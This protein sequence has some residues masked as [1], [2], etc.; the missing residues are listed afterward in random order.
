M[1]NLENPCN[2]YQNV[3]IY[4]ITDVGYTECYIGSTLQQLCNR[5]AEHRKYYKQYKK[6]KS[7]KH[8]TSY[9][10][11]DKHGVENCKIELIELYPCESKEDLHKREGHWI[12][13]ENCVNKHVA[14]RTY[15]EWFEHSKD[16]IDAYQKMYRVEN[17]E[18]RAAYHKTYREEHQE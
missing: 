9:L 15:K 5:I 8:V 18:K 10:L 1:E 3:K 2:K 6:G 13:Q 4:K 11:F 17:A 16:R 7:S 14:G 12:K